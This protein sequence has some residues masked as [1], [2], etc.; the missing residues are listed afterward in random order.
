MRELRG[1]SCIALEDAPPPKKMIACTRSFGHPV[2]D[3][4]PLIEAVSEYGSR[5]AEKLRRQRGL[6]G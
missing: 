6:A 5:A 1:E 4:G 2:G 3:L